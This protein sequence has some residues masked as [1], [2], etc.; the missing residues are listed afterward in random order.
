MTREKRFMTKKNKKYLLI[1]ANIF[2]LFAVIFLHWNVFE[3]VFVYFSETVLALFLSIVKIFYLKIPLSSKISNSVFYIF[4]F[5]IFMIFAGTVLFLYYFRQIEKLYPN[6]ELADIIKIIFN[7]SYFISLA[8][9]V[10]VDIYYFIKNYIGKK[11]YLEQTTQTLIR[12]PG[13]RIWLIVMIALLSIAI[14]SFKHAQSIYILII[15]VLLKTWIDI[16]IFKQKEENFDTRKLFK[17]NT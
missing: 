16:V 2:P 13:I 15:F 3:L 5:T 12:E 4:V 17:T 9:F 14:I 6:I 1:V 7:P 8:L 10:A 11:E